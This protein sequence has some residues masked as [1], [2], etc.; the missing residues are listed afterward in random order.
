MEQYHNNS[1]NKRSSNRFFLN[2]F[3]GARL[4]GTDISGYF[5]I[6]TV[7]PL[8]SGHLGLYMYR[9]CSIAETSYVAWNHINTQRFFDVAI[10]ICPSRISPYL[11]S[12]IFSN[13]LNFSNN[14]LKKLKLQF[15]KN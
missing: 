1:N 4:I 8:I 12:T 10:P 14:R 3:W 9:P 15:N 2:I 11:F 13:F 6:R 7:A 5:N